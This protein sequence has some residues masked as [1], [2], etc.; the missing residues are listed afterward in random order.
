MFGDG[1]LYLNTPKL[2]AV[3]ENKKGFSHAHQWVLIS[4]G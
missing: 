4:V 2:S 1:Q 3:A